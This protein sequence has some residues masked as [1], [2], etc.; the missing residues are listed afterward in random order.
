MQKLQIYSHRSYRNMK[1]IKKKNLLF[2]ALFVI[3]IFDSLILWLFPDIT[4]LMNEFAGFIL[5]PFY[6]NIMIVSEP[7]IFGPVYLIDISSRFPT[8]NFSVLTALISF[9]IIVVMIWRT[10]KSEPFSIWIIFAS[11]VLFIS[12]LFFVFY[13]NYFPYPLRTFFDLYIKT[14]VAIWL[15]IPILIT[16]AFIP[17]NMTFMSKFFV[18]LLALVYS[19]I[20]ATTRY[21]AFIFILREYS[22]LFMAILYFIFG[23]FLD[24]IYIVGIYSYIT[25]KVARKI[26]D[27]DSFWGWIF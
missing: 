11:I 26:K 9:L 18:V 5:S 25:S 27:K 3:I 21:V 7:F 14:V 1:N 15:I 20:F 4:L 12:S 10:D 16:I 8:F 19:I 23:P 24:F 6:D 22:S 13:G 2:R 17:L